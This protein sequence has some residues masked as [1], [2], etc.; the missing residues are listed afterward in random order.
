MGG[1]G[2]YCLIGCLA[3]S[4]FVWNTFDGQN[5]A[6]NKTIMINSCFMKTIYKFYYLQPCLVDSSRSNSAVKKAGRINPL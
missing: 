1:E 2:G 6:A 5:G 3:V 4:D